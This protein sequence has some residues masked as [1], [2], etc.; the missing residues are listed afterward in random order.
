MSDQNMA[1]KLQA[2]IDRGGGTGGGGGGTF[3]RPPGAPPPPSMVETATDEAPVEIE[4]SIGES[5]HR[6]TESIASYIEREA[7]RRLSAAKADHEN[8]HA[9]ARRVRKTGIG[10]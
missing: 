9:F 7:D 3:V 4:V 2:I 10:A 8:M 6:F 1:E 5:V